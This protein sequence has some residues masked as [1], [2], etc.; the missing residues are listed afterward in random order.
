MR[1]RQ[2]DVLPEVANGVGGV[3]AGHQ[4]GAVVEADLGKG[5]EAISYSN[6]MELGNES[7]Q[8]RLPLKERET[9]NENQPVVTW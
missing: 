3:E 4:A 2:G 9:A 5:G 7:A 8:E 6:H 1:P